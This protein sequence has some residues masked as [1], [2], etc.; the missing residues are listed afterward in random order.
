MNNS[1]Q[2]LQ[3]PA[4]ILIEN[5]PVTLDL[6]RRELCK[7]LT[8]FAFTELKGVLE[9]L[10]KQN[11]QAV[12]IEPEIEAQKGWKLIHTIHEDFPERFIPVIVCST[13]DNSSSSPTLEIT[14][15]MTKPVLPK[16]LRE[17]T[18]EV[19]HQQD[20]SRTHS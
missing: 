16:T 3:S 13:R 17:K 18:L 15:Y 20:N 6:Y 1:S 11:I 19:I 2:S 5:D 14:K 12:V 8:V 4:I 9:V 10:A 7:S